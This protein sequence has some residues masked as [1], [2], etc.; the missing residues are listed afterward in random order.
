MQSSRHAVAQH[1]VSLGN[2]FQVSDVLESGQRPDKAASAQ[3]AKLAGRIAAAPLAR[4]P[5]TVVERNAMGFGFW[6]GKHLDA[7]RKLNL[8]LAIEKAAGDPARLANLP[9]VL[10]PLLRDSLLGL[11]YAYYAPPGAQ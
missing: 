1:Q 4:A 9:E 2:L 7:E 10:A 3:M 6:S 11:S 5:L 8:R